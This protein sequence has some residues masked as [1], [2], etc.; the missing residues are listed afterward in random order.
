MVQRDLYCMLDVEEVQ[1]GQVLWVF[2]WLIYTLE[3]SN[4][5][6]WTKLNIFDPIMHTLF[7][8]YVL[9]QFTD[10]G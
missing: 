7:Q 8:V 4:K 6:R 9:G 3:L 2:P 10:A 1:L 5:W